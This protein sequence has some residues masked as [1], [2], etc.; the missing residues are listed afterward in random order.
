MHLGKSGIEL[1]NHR[2][3]EDTESFYFSSAWRRRLEKSSSRFATTAPQICEK[4]E[5]VGLETIGLVTTKLYAREADILD[6]SSSPDRVKEVA[7]Q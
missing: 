1:I 7:S 5:H 3:T 2:V 6:G 4:R